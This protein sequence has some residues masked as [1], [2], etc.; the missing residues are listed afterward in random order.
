MAASF[1]EDDDAAVDTYASATGLGVEVLAQNSGDESL[2]RYKR[3]LLAGASAVAADPLGRQVVIRELRI[4]VEGR[5]DIVIPLA[6]PQDVAA[7]QAAPKLVVKEGCEHVVRVV[8]SVYGDIV[9]GLKLTNTVSKLGVRVDRT[10]LMLGSYAPRPE[11]YTFST[12]VAEWP[13]GMLARGAYGART[14]F[15]DDDKTTHLD[16]SW[17]IEIKKEWGADGGEK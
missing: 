11:P 9:S 13:S 12:P 14:T 10:A 6:T 2:E 1:A 7:A 3:T 16:F 8:F 17:G 4:V 15:T 5:E